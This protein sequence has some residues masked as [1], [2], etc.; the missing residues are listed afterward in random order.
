VLMHPGL[1]I[2]KSSCPF[3]TKFINIRLAFGA[4]CR[5]FAP[6]V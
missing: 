2:R 1:A 3:H 4:E 5:N 6:D